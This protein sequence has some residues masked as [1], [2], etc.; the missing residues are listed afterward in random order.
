MTT[1]VDVPDS[2]YQ[3]AEIRSVKQGTPLTDIFL[4]GLE[5][6]LQAADGPHKDKKPDAPYFARRK[7]RDRGFVEVRA[8]CQSQEICLLPARA[9]GGLGS[10]SRSRIH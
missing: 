2:R 9:C 3:Q 4:R 6:E 5:R 1:T 7:L 8:L 10:T